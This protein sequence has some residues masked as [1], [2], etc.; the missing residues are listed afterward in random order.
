MKDKPENYDSEWEEIL[1]EEEELIWEHIDQFAALIMC[2]L[3]SEIAMDSL[4]R[5]KKTAEEHPRIFWR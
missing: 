4:G 2:F 3:D 5:L 1:K